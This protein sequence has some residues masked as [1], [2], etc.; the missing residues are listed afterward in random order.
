MYTEIYCIYI[1]IHTHLQVYTC[2]FLWTKPGCY[3]HTSTLKHMVANKSHAHTDTCSICASTFTHVLVGRAWGSEDD[4]DTQ[5]PIFIGCFKRHLWRI[6]LPVNKVPG[7]QPWN[8]V[9]SPSIATATGCCATA[10][11]IALSLSGVTRLAME[12]NV[13]STA[14]CSQERWHPQHGSNLTKA[15]LSWIMIDSSW[16]TIQVHRDS[17]KSMDELWSNLLGL[18]A[19][20]VAIAWGCVALLLSLLIGWWWYLRTSFV[21][22]TWY[23]DAFTVSSNDVARD[24]ISLAGYVCILTPGLDGWIFIIQHWKMMPNDGW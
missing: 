4:N 5:W 19:S 3:L 17:W 13:R 7:P 15:E 1:Y 16:W 12:K 24:I 10:R 8:T 20:I 6:A 22:L 23:F 2:P 11:I 14:C 21:T 9:S 18:P